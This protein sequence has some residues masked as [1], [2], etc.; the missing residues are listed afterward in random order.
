[1][2]P[3]GSCPI[4]VS[5][6]LECLDA[7]NDTQVCSNAG[8][9]IETPAACL[10]LVKNC[11][12][13]RLSFY[14]DGEPPSCDPPS[15]SPPPDTNDDIYGLDACRPKPARLVVL[16]DSIA[17]CL[18]VGPSECTPNQL[19]DH[20]KQTIAPGVVLESK[21]KS[22]AFTAELP[23]QAQAVAGGPGHV[24]VWVYAI[25]NDLATDK[26]DYLGWNKAWSEVFAYFTDTS[27][28]PDGA[29]FLLNTQYSPYDQCP[30]PP[31]PSRGVT[32]EQEQLL[33]DVNKALFID[34]AKQRA[35]SVAVDHYPDF[36]GHGR[37]A[38]LR[39]CPHCGADNTHWLQGDGTHPGPAG[40]A[41]MTE[42]WK[43]VFAKM[44]GSGC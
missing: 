24:L 33:Q 43:E 38:D 25:G 11:D 40:F 31:G 20:L 15:S 13:F 3:P 28:F 32:D 29:T 4:L 2:G 19:V 22:G 12:R 42:K 10:P 9:L 41:H 44:Y 18:G 35:D 1:M 17:A 36:L 5:D 14:Q 6:Y 16:G 23:V 26:I 8:Y 37:N 34:V 39:G 30:D 27:R 21:A 7:W